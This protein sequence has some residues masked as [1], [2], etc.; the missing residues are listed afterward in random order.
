MALRPSLGTISSRI[1]PEFGNK[2]PNK[3]D[4]SSPLSG[5]QKWKGAAL[6]LN[7]NPTLKISKEKFI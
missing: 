4:F 1:F 7:K 6:T 3:K 2:F 5:D